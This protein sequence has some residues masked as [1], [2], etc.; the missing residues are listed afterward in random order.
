MMKQDQIYQIDAQNY[1]LCYQF[2]DLIIKKKEKKQNNKM[3]LN[4]MFKYR[5]NKLMRK[6]KYKLNNRKDNNIMEDKDVD[7][8]HNLI[9]NNSHL[10]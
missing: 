9:I 7:P 6:Q 8:I 1:I 2:I 3:V 4:K 5:R 10:K